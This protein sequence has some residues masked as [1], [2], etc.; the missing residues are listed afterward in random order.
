MGIPIPRGSASKDDAVAGRHPCSER[1]RP[2]RYR[3]I[4]TSLGI[5]PTHF[6]DMGLYTGPMIPDSA[7][8]R[9]TARCPIEGRDVIRLH[10]EAAE[11][12]R[13]LAEQRTRTVLM[14]DGGSCVER[15]LIEILGLAG[16]M[17]PRDR[18]LQSGSP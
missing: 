1:N 17:P 18:P 15:P 9:D 4:L 7:K 16:D 13:S 6:A 8:D 14:C 3:T 11:L 2:R 12:M 10:S 5:I